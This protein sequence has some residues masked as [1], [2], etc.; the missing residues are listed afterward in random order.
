MM[1]MN[2]SALVKD[3]VPLPAG[4]AEVWTSTANYYRHPDW[5]GSSRFAS[6]T[7]RT[8]YYD[9]AYG[10][11]GEPYA[12]SGT[13]D[14]SYTGMNQDTVANLYD[15]PA[16]EY[17]I[18]GRWPSPD[19]AG[20]AAVDPTNPQSWNRYAYVGNNPL[21][22]IDPLGLEQVDCPP[23]TPTGTICVDV[24]VNGGGGIGN[25]P[26]PGG[27]TEAYVNGVDTGNTCGNGPVGAGDAGQS[28]GG[29]TS[30]GLPQQPSKLSE[31][32][33]RAKTCAKAYYGFNTL[34]GATT[35]VTRVGTLVA[36]AP[37]PKSWLSAIGIRTTTLGGGSSFTNILSVLGQGAGTAASGANVLRIAG[38][39]AG[40]MA[41]ASAAIDATAIA[42]CTLTD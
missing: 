26:N 9:G 32:L 31:T 10:P 28:R 36:A 4:A 30:S 40:P 17:G 19:P 3:F 41:I 29:G 34:P 33:T 12:Q 2:G 8:M 20:L 24:P 37:L 27:C 1:Y 18:Q 15:F 25:F 22:F 35:D 39:W 7:S 16:R 38:R 5:L 6:T 42:V 11:F 13:T 21:A 23:G 14:V